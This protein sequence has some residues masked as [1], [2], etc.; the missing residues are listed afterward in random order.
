MQ[1]KLLDTCHHLED[2]KATPTGLDC[3]TAS[4]AGFTCS[5]VSEGLPLM[6]PWGQGLSTPLPPS[7]PQLSHVWEQKA[8]EDVAARG[9]GEADLCVLSEAVDA[10]EVAAHGAAQEPEIHP[11]KPWG[12]VS[13]ARTSLSPPGTQW[14]S[15]PGVWAPGSKSRS[16]ACRKLRQL[17]AKV[18]VLETQ[19]KKMLQEPLAA[20]AWQAELQPQT[21]PPS[22]AQ[23]LQTLLGW[24]RG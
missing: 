2:Q 20:H 19:L 17:A 7:A 10:A 13:S 18:A 22:K 9:A 24:W 21:W 16:W 11:A 5:L 12:E 3:L 23:F 6:T 14:P 15:R 4:V 8:R 1:H